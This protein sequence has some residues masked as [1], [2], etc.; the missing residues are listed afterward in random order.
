[1][2]G[3]R[4]GKKTLAVSP[5]SRLSAA[6]SWPRM[7]SADLD[8]HAT[9]AKLSRSGLLDLESGQVGLTGIKATALKQ[10]LV[11]RNGTA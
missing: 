11:A 3:S 6:L 10:N 9:G 4:T 7:V 5:P 8:F 2:T 1:M